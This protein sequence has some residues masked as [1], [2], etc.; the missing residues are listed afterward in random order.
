MLCSNIQYT[1]NTCS[2]LPMLLRHGHDFVY[3]IEQCP[4]CHELYEEQQLKLAMLDIDE[5]DISPDLADKL[6]H[7]AI[8]S[9]KTK[10]KTAWLAVA[11]SVFVF[12]LLSQIQYFSPQTTESIPL[13][14]NHQNVKIVIDSADVRTEAHLSLNLSKNLAL[15]GFPDQQIL[16]WKTPL[17]KGKNLLTL[18][19]IIQ[20]QLP[21]QLNL[22]YSYGDINKEIRVDINAQTTTTLSRG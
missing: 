2:D 12:V 19:L 3:H 6:I 15:R 5:G 4:S 14:V 22:T 21:G 13:I 11:A 17:K 8:S 7:K 1:L 20:D 16:E 10:H 9:H 18:P